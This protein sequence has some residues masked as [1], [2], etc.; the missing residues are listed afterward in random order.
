MTLQ[1]LQQM[2]AQPFPP[3]PQQ[4]LTAQQLQQMGAQPTQNQSPSVGGFVGNAISSVGS[5][6]GGI[7]NAVLH[8]IQTIQN[9]GGAAVGAGEEG[10]NTTAIVTGKPSY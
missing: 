5:L 7:G 10:L 9:L 6:L 4:G 8:P 1:Q 3:N 2:G